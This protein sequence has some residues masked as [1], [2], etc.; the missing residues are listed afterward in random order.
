LG[1]ALAFFQRLWS[2]VNWRPM[3]SSVTPPDAPQAGGMW[4]LFWVSFAAL[5]IE[6]MMIRWMGTEV[7]IFA[8]FQNLALIACFMGFGLGCYWS[9]R[10]KS[11]LVS[12]GAMVALIILVQL[13]VDRWKLFLLTLSNMLSLSRD[14]ALWGSLGQLHALG[15]E[16]MPWLFLASVV[17]AAAFLVLLILAMV[18]LGQWVGYLLDGAPNPITAYS[19]NLLGSIAGIWIFAGMAFLWL[20]PEYWFGLA[21][22]LLLVIRPLPRRLTLA[23]LVV[24]AAGVAWLHFTGPATATTYWSPYQKLEVLSRDDGQYLI[25]VNNTG[26]MTVANMQPEFLARHPEIAQ[27]YTFRSAYDAPFRFARHSNRVL[28]VGAGAGNDAAGAL[29]N[30][31]EEVDAI[32]IDPAI[33]YLGAKLHPD[34]PYASPKVHR[35]LN[36]ARAYLR[37]ARKQYDVII[38]GFL[39]SHTEFSGYSNL[40]VDNYVYTEESFREAQR[41]LKPE[42]ILVVKFEV[43]A[44]WTWMGARFYEMLSGLFAHPPIIF[45]SPYFGALTGGT[46]FITSPDPQ[47]WTRAAE[48][49]LATFVAQNPPPFSPESAGNLPVATDDWPYI[50][51]FNHA[52]PSTYLT[53]SIILLVLAVLLMRGV[54]GLWRPSTLLFF[55]LGAGFL[56]L[57]TQLI[58]RLALYFGTTWLVNCVALTALLLVL[59]L[60][61]VFV[62]RARPGRLG[63]YYVLLLAGLLGNYFF[64]WARLLLGAHVVGILL[65]FAYAFP[66]FCAGVIF[67]EMFRRCEH[68]A[69]AFGANILGAVAGGLAQN[70]S[71]IVGMKALLLIAALLYVFAIVCGRAQGERKPAFGVGL[72]EVT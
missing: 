69:T 8:F 6:V 67:T 38:F 57:E 16:A 64:P 35:I 7:R 52:I 3:E 32:D 30:G 55:F 65:S 41:L 63:I 34:H 21:F 31:A 36:D 29:R 33:F 15:P 53:V 26:Y 50:Y 66:V 25:D 70:A 19:V 51:T 9:G 40:R 37:N 44:P 2:K 59:V 72:N 56:L 12:M 71:F 13:P 45:Y 22:L 61:N 23:G 58:S 60:A 24:L 54:A 28:I 14:T 10:R 39:D 27:T 43:R 17:T 62:A 18:P 48:V 11:L 49:P 68:K 20:S 47:L 1:G 46:V 5:Y 4:P 42:G